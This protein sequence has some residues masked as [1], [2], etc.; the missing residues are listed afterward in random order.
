MHFSKPY[1]FIFA[2]LF[3]PISEGAALPTNI[4]K[5]LP[6]GYEVLSQQ[7]GK[8]NDD[9]LTDYLVVLHQKNEEQITR[10]TTHAPLRPLLIF[11]QTREG[12]FKLVRRNDSVVFRIDE[13]EQCDPFED[14]MEGLAVK[15]GFFTIQHNVACGQHWIDFITF[16]Y[17]PTLQDWVFHKRV[18]ESWVLNPSDKPDAEA[19]I[20]KGG[21]GEKRLA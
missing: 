15:N 14:G 7:S 19:L 8:L 5:Q 11:I 12:N 17:D 6:P 9:D 3:H 2:F 18:S 4:L 21:V 10:K 1:F 13:G 20:S 16:R